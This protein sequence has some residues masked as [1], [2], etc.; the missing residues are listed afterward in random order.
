MGHVGFRGL[1]VGFRGQHVGFRGQHVISCVRG[2]N[3]MIQ[4]AHGRVGAMKLTSASLIRNLNE[5][6]VLRALLS[7]IRS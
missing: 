3:V 4:V 7:C 5:L 6:V 1:C 2:S